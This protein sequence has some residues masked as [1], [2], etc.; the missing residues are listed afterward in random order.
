MI[1]KEIEYLKSVLNKLKE[2]VYKNKE[3]ILKLKSNL[4]V[5][6]LNS[7][8]SFGPL[9]QFFSSLIDSDSE[10]DSEEKDRIRESLSKIKDSKK[11]LVD[12]E[13][14]EEQELDEEQEN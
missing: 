6:D 5:N 7:E 10:D 3:T 2:N 11:F 12:T 9:K 8:L 14:D 1:L 4:P 13:S